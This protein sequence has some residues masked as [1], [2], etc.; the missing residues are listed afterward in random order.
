MAFT[1]LPLI[2][3]A[4]W[5]DSL[6][7]ILAFGFLLGFAGASFAVGVPVRQRLVPA[8]APGL[9]AGHLRHGHG[10]HRARRPDRA[11]DRRPLGALRA[12][13]GRHRPD[14]RDVRASSSCSRATRRA[15]ADRPGARHVRRA[16]GVPHQRPGVGAHALLLPGLRRLRRHVPLPAQAAHRRAR[17][18]QGRRRRPRRRLRAARR[19]RPSRRRLAVGPRRRRPR[20]ARLVH[21][22]RRA[23]ARCSPRPT[24]RWCR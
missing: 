24:R 22:R 17:P 16:L 6:G 3:L 14:R 18:H 15:A 1:P 23:R 11:A 8:G 13:L 10:R 5:H 7:A 2:A 21:R 12:V 19:H 9:R 20:P 4:L